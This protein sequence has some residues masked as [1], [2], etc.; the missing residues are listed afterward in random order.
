MW[1][2]RIIK[3]DISQPVFFAVH[4]VF[5]DESG[6]VTSWTENPITVGGDSKKEVVKALRTMLSDVERLPVLKE[7]DLEKS[8]SQGQ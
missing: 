7:S 8:M 2:Y 6:R 4:E 3:H 1:N 5:Y